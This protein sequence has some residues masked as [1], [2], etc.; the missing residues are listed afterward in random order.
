[1][2]QHYWLYRDA[3]HPKPAEE[4]ST[5]VEIEPEDKDKEKF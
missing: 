5:Q 2:V 1:M 3:R 4:P